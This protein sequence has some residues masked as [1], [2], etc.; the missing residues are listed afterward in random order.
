MKRTKYV[1]VS[2]QKGG[3]GKTTLTVLLASYLHYTKGYNVAIIDCDFPQYSIAKMRQRDVGMITNDDYYKA[4]ARTLFKRIGKKAYPI[5][6]ATFDTA[7]DQAAKLTSEIKELDYIFFDLPGT[8]NMSGLIR[9]LSSMDYIFTPITADRV[10][11]ESSLTFA[12]LINEQI[13]TTNISSIKGLYVLWNM[14]DR[15]EKNELYD[16]YEKAIGEIGITIMNTSI[17]D[18]KRFRREA[19]ELHKPIFRSTLFPI[20]RSLIKSSRI[21]ELADEFIEI[22]Q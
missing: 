16:I 7:L 12:L 18:S 9:V 20:D 11:L 17:P 15:R 13:I 2:T 3:A 21:I 22:T 19:S 4:Q 8:V 14:V 6:E 10:V 1:A 5:M